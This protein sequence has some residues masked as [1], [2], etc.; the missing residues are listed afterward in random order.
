MEMEH[1]EYLIKSNNFETKKSGERQQVKLATE[2]QGISKQ[3]LY[4]NVL[5]DHER[6]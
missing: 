6:F 3:D 2:I 4:D 5:R 1:Y